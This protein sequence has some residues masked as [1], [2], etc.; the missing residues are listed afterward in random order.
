M[1][2]FDKL[3]GGS[4]FDCIA[5]AKRATNETDEDRASG[6]ATRECPNVTDDDHAQS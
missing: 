5:C 2:N 3:L 4:G 1:F 6:H